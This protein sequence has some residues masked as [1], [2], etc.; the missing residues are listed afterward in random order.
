MLFDLVQPAYGLNRLALDSAF[1]RKR[2]RVALVV[3]RG[4]LMNAGYRAVRRAGFFRQ[5]LPA[6]VLE[7]VLLDGSSRI[8]ALLRAIV[9]KSVFA[10]VEIASACAA[11]PVVRL[12]ICEIVL[13]SVYASVPLLA[14]TLHL[15]VN[16]ALY[17]RQRL[18][19]AETVVNDA[20][21]C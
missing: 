13:K 11:S 18:E 4:D 8:A 21:R 20:E 7:R 19:R 1:G 2:L 12:A 5:V 6:Y 3:E 9:N 10:D 17:S 15:V 14:K 16:L